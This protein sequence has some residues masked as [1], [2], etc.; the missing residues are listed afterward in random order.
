[1]LA[2]GGDL[3]VNPSVDRPQPHNA[4]AERAFLGGLI[5]AGGD[6]PDLNPGDFYLK[7]GRPLLQGDDLTP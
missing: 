7:P 4:E 6:S 3:P 2:G 5:L 1:V